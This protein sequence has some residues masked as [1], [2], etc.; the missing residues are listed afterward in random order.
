[1][2]ITDFQKN[3]F[4][5]VDDDFVFKS[6]S[7]PAENNAAT[8][9]SLGHTLYILQDIRCHL[10]QMGMHDEVFVI[11]Y[12]SVIDNCIERQ[13]MSLVP[14]V[15][16]RK[17][18]VDLYD[19]IEPCRPRVEQLSATSPFSSEDDCLLYWAAAGTIKM[20]D[21]YCAA[22][23]DLIVPLTPQQPSAASSSGN[24]VSVTNTTKSN[25][26][27]KTHENKGQ[28]KESFQIDNIDVKELSGYFKAQFKGI[29]GHFDYFSILVEDMK[30]LAL[31]KEMV[32]LAVMIYRSPSHNK[33]HRTFASWLRTFCKIVNQPC[34]KDMHPN[35][36]RPNEPMRVRFSYLHYDDNVDKK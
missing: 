13:G 27:A 34:P 3:K 22:I 24:V 35:K 28:K 10:S 32:M 8:A 36:Y 2:D 6:S 17:K 29:G 30:H 12:Q 11:L 23:R 7:V 14:S 16:G 20:Y 1:M 31:Q 21:E 4:S 9:E 33:K 5:I 18:I 26:P 25:A 19:L 15:E